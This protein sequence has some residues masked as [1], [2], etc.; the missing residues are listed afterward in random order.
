[1]FLRL[2]PEEFLQCC[3][4]LIIFIV[5]VVAALHLALIILIH[6]VGGQDDSVL[7]VTLYY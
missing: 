6:E 2:L 5:A 3:D 1:M 7:L 4:H